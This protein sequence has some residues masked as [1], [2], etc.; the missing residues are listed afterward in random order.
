MKRKPT[1]PM[2]V[3]PV[4]QEIDD[5]LKQVSVRV[6]DRFRRGRSV[7]INVDDLNILPT[8]T[9]P[10]SVKL[11][12]NSLTGIYQN[13]PP[14]VEEERPVEEVDNDDDQYRFYCRNTT[15]N[16]RYYIGEDVSGNKSLVNSLSGSIFDHDAVN[17]QDRIIPSYYINKDGIYGCGGALQFN[18]YESIIDNIRN[19][20][21]LT[22]HQILYIE[23]CNDGEY[24][25]I[26]LEYDR[27]LGCLVDNGLI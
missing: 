22:A 20:R 23:N 12:S 2:V 3:L 7:P 18:F 16:L 13:P 5:Y 1:R 24:I 25:N 8:I 6:A 17:P 11:K 4:I 21:R 9:N 26:I 27:V 14:S 10:N 15:S 19:Y